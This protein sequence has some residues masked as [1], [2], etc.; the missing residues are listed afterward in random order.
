[1]VASFKKLR[2]F[3]IVNTY[4][5]GQCVSIMPKNIS[6]KLNNPISINLKDVWKNASRKGFF[7]IFVHDDGLQYNLITTV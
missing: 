7:K 5:Y 2:T 6:A 3:Q 4:Y 1:M